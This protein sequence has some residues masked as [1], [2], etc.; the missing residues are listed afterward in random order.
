[1][2]S[3]IEAIC[4]QLRG[5]RAVNEPLRYQQQND[6]EIEKYSENDVVTT[7]LKCRP[8]VRT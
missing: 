4:L 8:A 6:V 2:S 1:M 3:E 7:E 5:G